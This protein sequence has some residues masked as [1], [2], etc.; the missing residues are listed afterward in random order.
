MKYILIAI[1]AVFPWMSTTA[2]P[3]SST[4]AALKYTTSADAE[5]VRWARTHGLRPAQDN[6][7]RLEAALHLSAIRP[8]LAG[9]HPQ[10]PIMLHQPHYDLVAARDKPR[11]AEPNHP[12]NP[13]MAAAVP[14]RLESGASPLPDPCQACRPNLDQ[15]LHMIVRS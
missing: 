3:A 4:E 7:G 6:I 5:H 13:Q 8:N 12:L 11:I 14:F 10:A 1:I 9:K 2:N 15:R